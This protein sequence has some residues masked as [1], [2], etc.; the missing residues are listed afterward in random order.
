ML[1]AAAIVFNSCSKDD[2]EDPINPQPVVPEYPEDV[3][4]DSASVSMLFAERFADE[5]TVATADSIRWVRWLVDGEPQAAYDKSLRAVKSDLRYEFNA[6]SKTRYVN[7]SDGYALTVDSSWN[8]VPDYTLAKYAMKYVSDSITLRVTMETV[9]PY[10]PTEKYF[11]IYT[12]EWLDRYIDNSKFI[13]SNQM[14]Y[15]AKTVKYDE[16]ILD[17]YSISVYSIYCGG[18]EKPYYKIALVRPL[19]QFKKFAMIHF[20]CVEESQYAVYDKILQSFSI[21][22][23]FGTTRNYMPVQEARPNPNWNEETAAFYQK[24]I[25]QDYLDFGVF[26]Y[27]MPGDDDGSYSS[28]RKLISAEKTR[29]EKV[30]NYNYA[31]MPT[32]TAMM[33]YS[34]KCYFPS[35]LANEF[36]GGNGFNGK[37]VLQFTYQYTTNNNLVSTEN[38]TNVQNP[39]FSI[40]RGK[41]DE[42]FREVARQIKEY[43]KPVLFRLN[44]EMNSDWTS[45]SGIMSLLDPEIYQQ[46]WK[47]LYNIFEEEGVDNCV[48][49]FNPIATSCPYSNW[50]EDLPY[51]PGND[52]VQAIGLTNYEMG[53]AIPMTSFRSRYTVCYNKNKDYFLSM[54]WIIS[55]FACGCGGSTSGVEKRYAKQ[56]AEWVKAMFADLNNRADNPYVQPI[57]GAIWFSCNDDDGY[58]GTVNYLKL[59]ESLTGTLKE[60]TD[61]FATMFPDK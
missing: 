25:S 45:Y 43:G 22:S 53:N 35:K 19:K 16:T 49:I 29:L 34:T 2:P 24:L 39:T 51:Y 46:T 48:W 32:Y 42:L 36:A 11:K 40:M 17:G 30:F 28:Q 38:T 60:F 33:W 4:T 58:G 47:R 7:E 14:K 1:L 37:P 8:L 13:G 27:S 9:Q 20:K 12:T 59:D 21:F 44:N 61:G 41:Y 54:P 52:Y 57:K 56:Q 10:T 50:G 31:I 55:E 18:L 3:I 15:T 5:G 6:G 23:S 26:S